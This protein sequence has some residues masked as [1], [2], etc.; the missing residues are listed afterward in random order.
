MCVLDQQPEV[1]R[2]DC[3]FKLKALQAENLFLLVLHQVHQYLNISS[4]LSVC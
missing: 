2:L 3:N 1:L 4:M